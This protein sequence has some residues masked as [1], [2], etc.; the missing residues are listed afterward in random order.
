ME[1]TGRMLCVRIGKE[2][3]KQV[4]PGVMKVQSLPGIPNAWVAQV[5]ERQFEEL[6][7]AGPTP[8]PSTSTANQTS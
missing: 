6:R 1:K 5:V 4:H 8:A 2:S 7:V 3:L